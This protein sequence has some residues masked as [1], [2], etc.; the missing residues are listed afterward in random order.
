[1]VKALLISVSLLY[2]SFSSVIAQENIVNSTDSIV[3]AST[4]ELENREVFWFYISL[5]ITEDR[6]TRQKM[7]NVRRLGTRIYSGTLDQ[8]DETVHKYYT[9]GHKFAI[10]PF[11]NAEEAKQALHFYNITKNAKPLPKDIDPKREVYY[12]MLVIKRM[13][14]RRP[15]VIERAPGRISSGKAK[16]FEDFLNAV[17]PTRVLA[18][19]P[20]WDMEEA[21]EAKRIYRLAD[22]RTNGR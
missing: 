21:E 20:F 3:L 8:F 16:D 12:F 5:R 4:D 15:Q 14:R 11:H 19:G 6:R 22:K 7:Y 10:G 2:F 17:L 13:K 18:V 1:M 9:S